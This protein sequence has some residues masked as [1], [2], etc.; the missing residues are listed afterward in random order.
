MAENE[1]KKSGSKQAADAAKTAVNV[2]K[3]AGRMAAGDVI[4]GVKDIAKDGNVQKII[5]GIVGFFMA[6][7]VMM[8]SVVPSV[9]FTPSED[10]FSGEHSF[11]EVLKQPVDSIGDF[12]KSIFGN[13]DTDTEKSMID[14]DSIQ[15]L[16]D[17]TTTDAENASESAKN[18]MNNMLKETKERFNKRHEELIKEIEAD[19]ATRPNGSVKTVNDAVTSGA[20]TSDKEAVNLLCLYSTQNDSNVINVDFNDYLDW[21]GTADKSWFRRTTVDKGG[22]AEEQDKWKKSNWNVK[23]TYWD[24]TMLPQKEMDEINAEKKK[25]NFDKQEFK[26]TFEDKYG[27][28]ATSALQ[29]LCSLEPDIKEEKIEVK[30]EN[31]NVVSSYM[32]YTY[33]IKVKSSDEI[34]SDFVNFDET[35][36][37]E[38]PINPN[39][40]HSEVFDDMVKNTCEYFGIYGSGGLSGGGGS[41]SQLVQVALNEV[42]YLEKASN[43]QLEDKTANPGGGNY[44]KY[45]QW[46]GMKGDFWCNI[47]VSWCANESGMLDD[48]SVPKFSL[49]TDGENWYKKNNRW[50]DKS[51]VPMTGNIIFFDWQRDGHTDHVGIVEKVENGKVFTIEGNSKDEVKEKIII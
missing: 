17:N 1:N 3:G 28:K 26:N 38:N 47:F 25:Y 30:D 37:D 13:K 7:I 21:L 40:Y 23:P 10:A 33:T 9:L 48:S 11:L 34:K 42:G 29:Q 27:D 45:G 36:D 14:S 20:T 4:G 44:T 43:S 46:F 22:P 5:G 8:T 19:F 12:L 24:G 31:G 2:A 39:N 49:C 35:K 32:N 50:K 6:M 51:Y 18:T 41:G 16:A 15:V